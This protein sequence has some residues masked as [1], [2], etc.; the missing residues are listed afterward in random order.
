MQRKVDLVLGCVAA[1]D[2]DVLRDNGNAPLVYVAFGR[3]CADR[4]AL[5]D[6]RARGDDAAILAVLPIVRGVIGPLLDDDHILLVLADANGTVR[7]RAGGRAILRRADQLAFRPGG[8]WSEK[9]VGTNAIGTALSTG[10]PV[11]VHAAEHFYLSHHGWSCAAAP[12]I[13]PRMMRPL[14]VIDLSSPA[15]QA[16]PMAV[17]LVAS[18]ARQIGVEL[19]EEHRRDLGRLAA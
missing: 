14:G 7:W 1:A 17:A 12:V 18:V 19:K 4:C 10:T 5:C 9:A 16:N 15:D 3:A 13:D 2:A 11:H 6:D 8:H